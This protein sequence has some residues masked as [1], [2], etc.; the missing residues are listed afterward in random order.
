MESANSSTLNVYNHGF[1]SSFGQSS[2]LL[3]VLKV[4][5]ITMLFKPAAN[6]PLGAHLAF[7]V[8]CHLLSLIYTHQIPLCRWFQRRQCQPTPKPNPYS[9]C[10]S[11]ISLLGHTQGLTHLLS[12]PADSPAVI[13]SFISDYVQK[14]LS[15]PN[16][17]EPFTLFTSLQRLE[18]LKRAAVDIK[19]IYPI[20]PISTVFGVIDETIIKELSEEFWQSLDDSERAQ[21]VALANDVQQLCC[22]VYVDDIRRISQNLFGEWSDGTGTILPAGWIDLRVQRIT[23]KCLLRSY[24]LGAIPPIDVNTY[25]GSMVSQTRYLPLKY[26]LL[27]DIF[28]DKRNVRFT[29]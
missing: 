28:P 25:W 17:V 21:W 23:T 15:H 20:Q 2:S 6:P 3:L 19:P 10:K 16:T 27:N 14:H 26:G 7:P 4:F 13:M 18:L 1:F 29:I 24:K 11:L 5:S 9:Y 12:Q 22:D 8:L